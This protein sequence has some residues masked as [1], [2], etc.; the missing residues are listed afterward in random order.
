L[1][2]HQWVFMKAMLTDAKTSADLWPAPDF[3]D[4]NTLTYG[5][6]STRLNL[7]VVASIGSVYLYTIQQI[8]WERLYPYSTWLS[9]VLRV[10]ATKFQRVL[11]Y[12]VMGESDEK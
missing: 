2:I 12:T 3:R 9:V 8:G 11:Q 6:H 7:F 10:V 5:F 1:A 4:R